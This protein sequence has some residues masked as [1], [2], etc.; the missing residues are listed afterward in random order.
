MTVSERG[1][2]DV[3]RKTERSVAPAQ[4]AQS[5][6]RC[7]VLG[8]SHEEVVRRAKAERAAVAAVVLA[9]FAA[10]IKSQLPPLSRAFDPP[11]GS[12]PERR[13]KFHDGAKRHL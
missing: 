10:W 11:D 12:A 13:E 7:L 9:R 5:D 1:R 2:G 3:P 4:T 8:P 6:A